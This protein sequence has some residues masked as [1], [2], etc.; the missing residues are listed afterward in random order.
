MSDAQAVP[1]DALPVL[2]ALR[3][4]LARIER[5]AP[6]DGVA[7]LG[8]AVLDAALPW[9]GLRRGGLHEIAGA[10]HEAAASGFA[11][12]LLAR[13]LVPASEANASA[14]GMVLWCRLARDGRERGVP[15]GPGLARFGLTPSRLILVETRRAAEA[16]WAM[17]EGLRCRRLVAVLGEG[18]PCD[19]VASRRLQLAAEAGGATALL[20]SH[21]AA[22]ASVA[23]SRWRVKPLPSRPLPGGGPGPP[24]W[25]VALWRCRG[26]GNGE[27]CV[28]WNDASRRFAVVAALADRPLAAAV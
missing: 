24:R 26:G 16:L 1:V 28:E 4:E 23:L 15:Y 7:G 20:V 19:L 12:G 22:S 8:D 6:V 18:L 17:E 13:L 25:Q 11:A 10:G 27:W 3:V 5:H 14:H 9:G 21:A 2:A